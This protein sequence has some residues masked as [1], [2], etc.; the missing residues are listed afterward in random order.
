VH[1]LLLLL[2]AGAP[3]PMR[4]PAPHLEGP[5]WTMDVSVDG[6]LR[7][8]Q[9]ATLTIKAVARAGFHVNED[10]PNKFTA[11]TGG[12]FERVKSESGNGLTL[13]TCS[14]D[15]A[16]KCTATVKV[17]VTPRGNGSMMLGGVLALG[18]CDKDRCLIDK[19]PVLIQVDVAP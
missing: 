13:D 8:D 1:A 5:S 2:L 10:Y 4:A 14:D 17:R 15:S 19:I 12:D 9:P 7:Q 6:K 11:D 3:P 18:T 16:H